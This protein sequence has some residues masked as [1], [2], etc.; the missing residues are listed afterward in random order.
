MFRLTM[1][2]RFNI[3]V[4]PFLVA[5]ARTP[6]IANTTGSQLD[7]HTNRLDSRCG[8]LRTHH[9]VVRMSSGLGRL[10][11]LITTGNGVCRRILTT[12]AVSALMFLLRIRR[13]GQLKKWVN[14]TGA[15]AVLFLYPL[16]ERI[17]SRCGLRSSYCACSI[18]VIS[19]LALAKSIPSWLPSYMMVESVSDYMLSQTALRQLLG[20]LEKSRLLRL[21]QMIFCLLIPTIRTSPWLR[22]GTFIRDFILFYCLWCFLSLY[23]GTKCYIKGNRPITPQACAKPPQLEESRLLSTSFKPLMDKLAELQELTTCN[24]YTFTEILM[25]SA[26]VQSIIPSFKWAL[27]KRFCGSVLSQSNLGR[28]RLMKSLVLMLGFQ[29]LDQSRQMDISPSVLRYMVR[30][31]FKEFLKPLSNTMQMMLILASSN[32]ALYNTTM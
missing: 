18:T 14:N 25:N 11:K 24:R 4:A 28:T 30:V 12:Y 5:E 20:G 7:T 3:C 8:V 26:L 19:S 22:R 17:L 15:V 13:R 1:V 31:N 23:E 29:V 9:S 2:E 27:C 10:L 32:L 21:R 6:T 16:V